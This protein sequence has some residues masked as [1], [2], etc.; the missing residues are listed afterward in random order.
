MPIT[1]PETERMF[2]LYSSALEAKEAA[3]A[4]LAILENAFY[5]A[6]DL[7]P[8]LGKRLDESIAAAKTLLSEATEAVS[9]LRPT[10]VEERGYSA[11]DQEVGAFA[12]S[13]GCDE[14]CPG[15]NCGSCNKP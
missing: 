2:A 7:E 11:V 5:N 12:H 15:G 10:R 13:C 1:T 8:H 3:A 6:K 4:S 14:S 9:R